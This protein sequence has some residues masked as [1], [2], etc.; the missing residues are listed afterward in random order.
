MSYPVPAHK[1]FLTAL[2]VIAA[3]AGLYLSLRQSEEISYARRHLPPGCIAALADMEYTQAR[4]RGVS[5]RDCASR[6]MPQNRNARV[7]GR[8]VY[9]AASAPVNGYLLWLRETRGENVSVDRLMHAS[10]IDN[11]VVLNEFSTM[12]NGCSGGIKTINLEANSFGL[13]VNLTPAALVRLSSEYAYQ[14]GDLIDDPQ[15]CVARLVMVDR[16]AVAI[17]L[18]SQPVTANDTAVPDSVTATLP[19][20]Q[21][22][23][24]DK[25]AEHLASGSDTLSFP[26]GYAGFMAG[27][28]AS[29]TGR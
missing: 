13:V 19:R 1:P 9:G 4:T 23:L 10:I 26:Q 2:V 15:Y 3:L 27:Y 22:C 7:V 16:R 24:N 21:R 12:G 29:C 28:V 20:R 14:Q 11:H 25:I 18:N 8:W 17:R 5:L 6:R